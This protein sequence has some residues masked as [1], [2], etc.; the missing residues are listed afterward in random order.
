MRIL[1]V[2]ETYYPHLNGVYYFVCRIAPLLQEKGH[3]VAVIAPSEDIHFAKKKIDGIDVYVMPSLPL[4]F[5]PKLRF[6]I[7]FMLQSKIEKII[8]DFKPDV[9]HLQDHFILSKAVVEINK[10]LNIPVIGTNHFMPEN[11]T[12][13]FK[14]K[15]L[16]NV[17]ERFLWSRFSQVFNQVLLVT[18]P[19]ETGARLIRPHLKTKVIPISS[20]ISL[21][22]FNASGQGETIRKKYGLTDKPILLYVGRIDPEKRIEEILEAVAVAVKTVDFSF[23]V[24]GNGVC[25]DSLE[26]RSVALNLQDRVIFT[27]FVPNEDLPLFYRISRCFIIASRAELL[28]L[29]TLQAMAS[30]LPV[31]AVNAGALPE[32]VRDNVNG[33]LFETGEQEVIVQSIQKIF[34][35]KQLHQGMVARSLEFS[36]DHDIIRT[37]SSFE[38]VYNGCFTRR[39][40]T[41]NLAYSESL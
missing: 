32:L 10:K 24:V 37:V 26:V 33:F 20:G 6:P 28:S 1:F 31:I 22:E 16:K 29:V 38:K 39:I 14:N 35:N 23:V 34:T 5:Y 3:E 4:L 25:K 2:S 11:I 21:E 13:L 12:T 41:K 19:T 40:I 27:G 9:I 17:V 7:P 15:R 8:H 18:T 30:G 36:L